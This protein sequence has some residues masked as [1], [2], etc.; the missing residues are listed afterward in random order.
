[1]IAPDLASVLAERRDAI[2]SNFVARLE[3][4]SPTGVSRSLLVDHIPQFLDEICLEVSRS[5]GVRLSQDVND[6]SDTAR[7]H[8]EQ[9]WNIGTDL[10]GLIREYGVLR[11]CI[12]QA[13]KDAGAEVSIDD[14]DILAKCL[15]VGV[16]EAVTEYVAYREEQLERQKTNLEFLATAGEL[17][18]SS[19]DYRSTLARLTELLVPR[20]ADWCAV[21]LEGS[22]AA[23]MQIAHVDAG[24]LATV[25]ELFSRFPLPND[26]PVGYPHAIRTGEPLLVAKVDWRALEALPLPPEHLAMLRAVGL[27]SWLTVPLRVQGNTVGALTLACAESGRRYGPEDLTLAGEVARRA[28][29]AI[30]NARLYELSQK[31]RSRVEAA[32][33]AK[34]EFVALVSHELRTPLNAI[35]GWLGLLRGGTLNEDKREHAFAVIERNAMAQSQIVADLLD[36]SRVIT[37]TI[38]INPAQVDLVNV[39]DMAVEGVRP[40]AAAKGITLSVE[41]GTSGSALMRGDG[42]RLQQVVWNLLANAVK[43]TPKRGN[44]SVRLQR[45]ESDLEIVVVDDGAGIPASFLPHVFESFRQL[46][47]GTSRSHGGLGVG[48][49]IAKHIA[50][51]HGGSIE[52]QSRGLGAG[53]LFRVRLPVSPVLSTTYGVSR[54]PAT[55]APGSVLPTGLHGIRVLAVDD[56]P[57]A[58]ELLAYVLE[59]CG[60]EVK[61]A[62]SVAEALRELETFTPHVIVSDIGMREQDG[63][64]LIRT[65]RTLPSDEKKNIPAIAL[66]AYARNDDRTRALVE[67]FNM[68]MAKPV[69]PSALVKAVVQLAGPGAK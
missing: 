4:L 51:L 10:E 68:H 16:A 26:A 65:V 54:V 63:Y 56:E 33:R 64:T 46:D 59:S 37:G 45:V 43:F 32:T 62:A 29:V 30:D 61:A 23:E 8:G 15:S 67:G 27:Q 38:R 60:M 21:H 13:M 28:A 9:R 7:R 24:K 41:L 39:V 31:E 17:L 42:D 40:A 11:H 5:N 20:L 50:E 34:D 53:A 66:T 36:I 35:L 22:S 55:T 2:V 49:S 25:R 69:E 47:A 57:D 58:R 18:S 52:A 6:T 19:L 44:I 48:L 14:F 1:M 3:K 12:L